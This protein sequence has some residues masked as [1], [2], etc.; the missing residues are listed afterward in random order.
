[1]NFSDTESYLVQR[2]VTLTKI[3]EEDLIKV[4][5]EENVRYLKTD[6]EVILLE[7]INQFKGKELNIN[8]GE[9]ISDIVT[10][11]RGIA[12]EEMIENFKGTKTPSTKPLIKKENNRETVIETS[13][14]TF[15]SMSI[16]ITVLFIISNTNIIKETSVNKYIM[17]FG[18][19]LLF[20]IPLVQIFLLKKKL[21]TD[22][23]RSD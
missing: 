5:Q 14:N 6:L 17:S 12:E 9:V 10:I 21:K 18:T 16:L 15:I 19:F 3:S 22:I 4:L 8:A 13:I 11:I 23:K 1:M 7:I 2:V 20:L